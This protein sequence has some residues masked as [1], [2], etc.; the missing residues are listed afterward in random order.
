MKSLKKFKKLIVEGKE[1]PLQDDNRL[2]VDMRIPQIR[3]SAYKIL[4]R[5][6]HNEIK[7]EIKEHSIPKKQQIKFPSRSISP[8]KVQASPLEDITNESENK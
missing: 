7:R 2:T 4:N 1:S 8:V 6:K 5:K 3:E